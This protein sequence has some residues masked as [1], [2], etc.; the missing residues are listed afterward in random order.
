MSTW[1]NIIN[2]SAAYKIF[3]ADAQA[4]GMSGDFCK[5]YR[6][7]D[8]NVENSTI[9][10][11]N[12]TVGN[13]GNCRI[14]SLI[15]NSLDPSEYSGDLGNTVVL[16]AR[17]HT[18][19]SD[20]SKF[21]GIYL[22]YTGS[23]TF[24][25][26]YGRLDQMEYNRVNNEVISKQIQ[27]PGTIQIRWDVITTTDNYYIL[28][29]LEMFAGSAFTKLVVTGFNIPASSYTLGKIGIGASNLVVGAPK[30]SSYFDAVKIYLPA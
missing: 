26:C 17:I 8:N 30:D 14:E 18:N 22:L 2:T 12:D 21:N 9:L 5:E 28:T 6:L 11:V 29:K 24:T 10:D 27:T 13:V 20:P 15:R 7:F 1:T 23:R 16:A 19:L 3:Y 25:I 4:Q